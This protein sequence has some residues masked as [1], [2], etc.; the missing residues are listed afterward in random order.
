MWRTLD[1]YPNLEIS[2]TGKVFNK[3]K[4]ELMVPKENSCGYLR[5]SFKGKVRVFVHRLVALAFIPN[6]NNYPCVNH[7][8]G[9]KKNNV[10][11]NLEWVTY[12][13]N[14]THAYKLGLEKKVFGEEHPGYNK[15]GEKS[16]V[17]RLSDKQRMMIPELVKQGISMAQ[18]ARDW[19]VSSGCVKKTYKKIREN[20]RYLRTLK[21]NVN[22][23]I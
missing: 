15:F 20:E 16:K 11:T 8:D 10:S 9:N 5:V 1:K 18:I 4:G 23:S 21:Q 17:S 13:Q 22:E 12:S 19:G 14:T 2:D 7:K 6:P 3:D